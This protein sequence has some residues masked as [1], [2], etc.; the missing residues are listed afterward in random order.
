MESIQI[1]RVDN[2]K[3]H[4]EFLRGLV[5]GRSDDLVCC[6]GVRL[7]GEGDLLSLCSGCNENSRIA[8]LEEMFFC[9]TISTMPWKNLNRNKVSGGDQ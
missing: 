1:P 7:F 8:F 9:V 2:G 3:R 5:Y 4:G 6:I